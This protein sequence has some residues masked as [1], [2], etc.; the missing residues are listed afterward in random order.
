MLQIKLCDRHRLSVSVS[1][2]PA[3][4]SKYNPIDHRLFCHVA[5]SLQGL[6]LGSVE[7]VRNAIDQTT[8]RAGLR[9]VTELARKLYRKGI[10]AAPEY[11][12]NETVIRD[13]ELP[14]YNYRFEPR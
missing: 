9:V 5:R 2:Y 7:R 1:H 12:A 13:D 8:T 14:K 4:A 11:L 6:L 10:K 3:G